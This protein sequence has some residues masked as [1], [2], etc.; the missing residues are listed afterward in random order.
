MVVR[1]GVGIAYM[2]TQP[3]F[4]YD[5]GFINPLIPFSLTVAPSDFPPGYNLAFPFPQATFTQQ[6][7]ANPNSIQNLGIALSRTV[8]DHHL[9]DGTSD[10]W[11]LSVQQ[12]LA[13]NLAL[14]IAYVGNR[15]YHLYYNT[16]PNQFLPHGGPRPDPTYSTVEIMQNVATSGYNAL[17]VSLNERNYHGLVLDAYYTWGK[18]LSY[19]TANDINNIGNNNVQDLN[20]VAGSYGPVDGDIRNVFTLDYSYLVPTVAFA[21]DSTIGRAVFGGW[22]FAG[23]SSYTSGLPFNVLSGLDLVRNQRITGDRPNA[24]TGVNRYVKNKSTR[25]WLNP[26]AFDNQTPYNQQVFGNLSYNATFGPR[27]FSYDAA[28]HKAFQITEGSTLTFRAESFN[29]LNHVVFSTP[30]NTMTTPTFGTI[31]AGSSG[32]AFQLALTYAF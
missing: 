7:I 22:H 23:I 9:P 19:G 6:I 28:L 11:N 27:Q 2:Q 21:R 10:Q 15:V 20:N 32:R 18:T 13:S 16:L 3:Y 1:A 26:A 31:L 17:Q 14:Q 25:Q 8:A 24:V 5:F 29:V 30:Q 12:T 4:M